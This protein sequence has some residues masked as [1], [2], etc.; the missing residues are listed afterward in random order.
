MRDER[1]SRTVHVGTLQHSD[2]RATSISGASIV[3]D[4]GV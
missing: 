4:A 1:Q 3:D 2:H